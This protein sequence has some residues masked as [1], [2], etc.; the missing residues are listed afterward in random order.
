MGNRVRAALATLSTAPWRRAPLLLWR[1]PGVLATVA[2]ATAMLA[3]PVAAIPLFLSS[4]GSEG[5]AVQAEER[6]PRDTGA[7]YL[8][9]FTAAELRDPPPDPFAPLA[10]DLEPAV[11]WARLGVSLARPDGSTAPP[12][13]LLARDG[14]V[15]HVEVVDGSPGPGLWISD[16]AAE[17]T[18]L[19]AGDVA[20]IVDP[21][22]TVP[23]PRT[24]QMEPMDGR[25]EVPIAGVYR[26]LAGPARD[27]DYWCSHADLLL[28]VPDDLPPPLVLADRATMAGLVDAL[29]VD[30]AP[31]AWEAS[32][33]DGLTPARSQR[34][35]G[36]LACGSGAADRLSWC[37][38]VEVAADGTLTQRVERLGLVPG[39]GPPHRL[40]DEVRTYDGAGAFVSEVLTS[41]L[42]YVTERTQAIQSS[43]AGGVVPVAVFAA[44]AGAG[45]VAA[46]ASLWFDR[47]RREVA[48]LTVRGVS[49][50]GMGVKAVL[51]LAAPLV[52]GSAGGVGLAYGL[53]VWLGPSPVVE[54]A[55]VARAAAA[56][57]AVLLA[58]AL[59]VGAV[60]AVRVRRPQGGHHRLAW[61]PA[62]PW[63]AV[64]AGLTVV[65][66]RRLGEWGVPV[67]R[68]A[69]LTGVDLLGL[70]FPLLFLL[71]GVAVAMRLLTLALHRLRRAGRGWPPALYLAVRRV[72]GH[73]AAVVGLV[74]ASAVAAGV[75]AYATTLNRS[76][77]ATLDAKA[78]TFVGS[79]VAASLP[80]D[81]QVPS[82]LSGAATT[83][84]T[85]WSAWVDDGSREKVIVLA[86]DPATFARAAFWDAS[87]ADVPLDELLERLAAPTSGRTVPAL[88]V[89]ADVRGTAEAGIVDVGTSEFTIE[90]VA[91]VSA[92]PGMKRQ[93][94]TMLVA[95]AALDDLGV[96]GSTTEVWIRGDPDEIRRELAAA[97]PT[98]RET[99]RFDDVV[100]RSAF[101]TVSWTFGFMRSLAIAA[102]VLTVGGVA[103]YS[104]ARRRGRVLG[105]AF[106]RRMGLARSAHRRAILG[107]LAASV[108]AG[109]WLG[110]G[111][112]VVGAGLAYGRIDPVPD[113]R[114]DPLLRPATAVV[115]ALAGG[116]VL[117]AAVAAALA[118]RRADRDDPVEV[119][120]AGV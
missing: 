98:L 106:A 81:R 60:V 108:V 36:H 39:Q 61:L 5:I 120:R 7:T 100:D 69:D 10:G 79:D 92:L 111:L 6:C 88:I 4:A 95:A 117:V 56:G 49:P 22:L 26:D 37:E 47:R 58:A 75:L 94:P 32:L 27:D 67:A 119:L 42:P 21:T 16:R 74:A 83:I 43:V 77:A 12:M 91:D 97:G 24:P 82:A 66:Y 112:A 64:A 35:V 54:P 53:V 102:G 19:G 72:A 23:A 1:R 29:G 90:P 85:Y 14:A 103:V 114:P 113:F 63:E 73:R 86:V 101:L 59:L 13:P 40:P 45:L 2:G 105:Y 104:D 109:C 71:T 34:L 28:G 51:E 76:L 110:L 115:V 116:A 33:R 68:G 44:L 89:G 87:F 15:D 52:A 93:T 78:R 30:T 48:L 57:A 8:T 118:Q 99:R 80:S 70:V 96:G 18:R 3:A 107:E 9:G 41:R 55:A 20:T 46:A 11:S 50:A 84:D 65:S 31:G 25:M 17:I 62:V 38:D